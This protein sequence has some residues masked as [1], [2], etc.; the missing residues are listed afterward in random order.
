MRASWEGWMAV[1]WVLFRP[2]RHSGP[3]SQRAFNWVRKKRL[4]CRRIIYNTEETVSGPPQRGRMWIDSGGSR[5]ISNKRAAKTEAELAF[6]RQ[7]DS[8]VDL[9]WKVD[10]GVCGYGQAGKGGGAKQRAYPDVGG[11]ETPGG[12]GREGVMTDPAWILGRKSQI[13][14]VKVRNYGGIEAR[15]S[16]WMTAIWTE[17]RKRCERHFNGRTHIVL[18]SGVD[19]KGMSKTKLTCRTLWFWECCF[20]PQESLGRSH[21]GLIFSAGKLVGLALRLLDLCENKAS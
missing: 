7:W 1:P 17:K 15:W 16:V 19:T 13:W 6:W 12:L 14:E 2:P 18:P 3:G 5:E 11:W 20:H 21:R 4:L 8:C 9:G 10:C